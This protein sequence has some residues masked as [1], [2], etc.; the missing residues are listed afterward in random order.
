M[1]ALLILIALPAIGCASKP[2]AEFLAYEAVIAQSGITEQDTPDLY[3]QYVDA[4]HAQRGAADAPQ[5]DGNS[6][7]SQ[8]H[9]RES[10]RLDGWTWS[11]RTFVGVAFG[12][13]VMIG[14]KL[15]REARRAKR[16]ESHIDVIMR[17]AA[18]SDARCYQGTKT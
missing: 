13:I 7:G 1:K 15:W 8:T 10:A 6:V 12:I 11:W 2:T 14:R 4:Y 3:A 18:E 17:A 9:E 16:E 5:V